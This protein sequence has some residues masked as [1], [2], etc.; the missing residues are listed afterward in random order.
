M[1]RI[2]A[3]HAARTLAL[4]RN[5]PFLRKATRLSQISGAV[6]AG[7]ANVGDIFRS[8]SLNI[9]SGALDQRCFVDL[10]ED[11]YIA[12]L[13]VA[14]KRAATMR[15]SIAILQADGS[16]KKCS[17]RAAGAWKRRGKEFLELAVL[18]KRGVLLDRLSVALW[19]QRSWGSATSVSNAPITRIADLSPVEL[20]TDT[21]ADAVDVVFT[22]VDYSDSGWRSLYEEHGGGQVLDPDRFKQSDELKYAIRSV[23]LYAPWVRNIII[24]SNC[25][26]P[27]WFRETD[28]TRW[29]DHTDVI[30]CQY[31]PLFN[32]HAIET[33]LHMIPGLSD[34]F[35]Y[36]NDDFF[37]CA[38]AAYSDF[39]TPHGLTVSRLELGGT[40]PFFYEKVKNGKADSWEAATVNGGRLIE[41]RYG[42]W[43]TQ[44]H[45]HAPYAIHK[46]FFDRILA[47]APFECEATR[48]SRFRSFTDVPFISFVY[49]HAAL[50]EGKACAKFGGAVTLK[51]SNYRRYANHGA[52]AGYKSFCIN[53]GGGSSADGDY[54]RFK[55]EFPAR[56]FPFA[57]LSEA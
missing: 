8:L 48:Q 17:G 16:W 50:H 2:I 57:L 12:V 55:N 51:P 32:S 44:I 53:D 30:P 21:K 40:V 38:P 36:L 13:A 43:P 14:V 31:L 6:E 49:H 5:V 1:L 23:R 26:P 54:G 3:R 19:R 27:S 25:S 28:N 37:L 20:A 18:D 42:V 45:C 22:W 24:F 4:V 15:Q 56:L 11:D 33:F 47:S 41:K 35:L 52:L 10:R 46:G 39:F 7:G 29:V 9:T 34:K